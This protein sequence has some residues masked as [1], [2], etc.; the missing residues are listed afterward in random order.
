MKQF[1]YKILD[2]PAAGWWGGRIDHQELV[3]KL[4]ELGRQGWDAVTCADT[5]RHHGSSKAVFIILKRQIND[6]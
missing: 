5:N 4:N 3:V 2:V 6:N 1:E